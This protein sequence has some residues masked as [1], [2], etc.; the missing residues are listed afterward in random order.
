MLPATGVWLAPRL[1][2]ESNPL[3][4]F[5][6]DARIVRD[7]GALDASLTGM[8]PSQVVILGG[9]DDVVSVLLHTTG[10]RKVFGLALICLSASIP[11]IRG[12]L[13]SSRMTMASSSS[14]E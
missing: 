7:F 2:V 6:H 13:I 1:R 10:M 3:H 8:L 5:P 9:N 11:S 12:M 4:F 14:I